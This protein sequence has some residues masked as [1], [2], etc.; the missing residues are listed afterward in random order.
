MWTGLPKVELFEDVTSIFTAAQAFTPQHPKYTTLKTQVASDS[1]DFNKLMRSIFR[2]TPDR[3]TRLG[4]VKQATKWY[5]KQHAPPEK[6]STIDT[7]TASF[8]NI[9]EASNESDTPREEPRFCSQRRASVKPRR[10]IRPRNKFLPSLV[11]LRLKLLRNK[12]LSV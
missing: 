9:S 5:Y 12:R 1:Q 10:E 4:V 2:E 8:S 6:Q 3:R 7:L 11:P